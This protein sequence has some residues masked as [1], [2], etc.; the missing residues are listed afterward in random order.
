MFEPKSRT[1][2]DVSP[3]DEGE[4]S[5]AELDQVIGGAP[6][7]LFIDEAQDARRPADER[8][9]WLYSPLSPGKI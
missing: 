6:C 1:A 2:L 7:R 3:P 4:L 9:V 5:D 8:S